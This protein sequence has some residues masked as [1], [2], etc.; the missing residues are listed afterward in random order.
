VIKNIHQLDK[1]I[2]DVKKKYSNKILDIREADSEHI[3]QIEPAIL[4]EITQDLKN[5]GYNQLSFVTAVD[6]NDKFALVYGIFSTYGKDGILLK[7]DIPRD[8]PEIGSVTSIWPAANWHE[9]E[10][11]DLFGIDFTDHPD[12][13]RIFLPGDWEGHPLRKDFTHPNMVRRPDHY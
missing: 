2:E 13:R 1:A 4:L 5:A 11:F 9:R 12:L 7:V 10:V 6:N 3:I 8:K